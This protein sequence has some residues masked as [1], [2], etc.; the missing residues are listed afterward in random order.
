VHLCECVLNIK[1]VNELLTSSS[2]SLSLFPWSRALLGVSIILCGAI[3]W[4]IWAFSLLCDCCM[5]NSCSARASTYCGFRISARL[6]FTLAWTAL[7]RSIPCC[8]ADYVFFNAA[9]ERLQSLRQIH[10]RTNYP[11]GWKDAISL[12]L[13]AKW[14]WNNWLVPLLRIQCTLRF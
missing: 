7:R 10:T 2:S 6:G 11:V 14:T 12:F 13:S 9:A 4:C 8:V 1:M 3:S 5:V